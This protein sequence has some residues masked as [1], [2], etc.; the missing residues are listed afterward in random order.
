M[1]EPDWRRANRANWDERVGIHLGPRGYDLSTLRAGNRELNRIEESELPKVAGKRIAHLQCH[2]GLDTLTLAQY[3]AEVVGLDFSAPAIE[4]ARILTDELGLAYRVQ[5]VHADLYD[6]PKAI[7]QP[8]EFDLVFVTWGAICW[9]PDIARWAQIVAALL[10]RGGSIYLAEGHPAA[11]VFDDAVQGA[12]GKTGRLRS[13][14]FERTSHCNRCDRLR[15]SRSP[16][17]QRDDLQLDPPVGGSCHEPDWGGHGSGLAA[18]ARCR[19]LAYV[20]EPR[21]GC[22]RPLSMA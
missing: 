17:R 21:E 6:A 22:V 18:R 13:V 20:R 1:I 4:A 15:G 8:H 11:H 19:T 3:G 5:F 2:F 16:A 12:D 9:L 7:P 10:R 14:L